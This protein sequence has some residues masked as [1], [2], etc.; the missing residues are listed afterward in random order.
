MHDTR[1][2]LTIQEQVPLSAWTSLR[3]GGPARYFVT[4]RSADVVPNAFE[5]AR[6]QSLPTLVLGGGSNVLVS[7]DGF[8]GTVIHVATEGYTVKTEGETAVLVRVAAGESWDDFVADAVRNG[9]W[10]IENL[11]LI[12]GKV[13]AV[14]IQNV[15]AYGQEVSDTI[16]SVEAWDTQREEWCTL[17]PTQ[18]AFGYRQSLFN[19][20]EADRYVIT[21][22]T[23]RLH[24]HGTPNLTH[25]AVAGALPESGHEASLDAMRRC[26][27][28]LR[29][30]GRL[31]DV[32]ETGNVGSF[33]KHVL[34]SEVELQ[35]MRDRMAETL[36]PT[37]AGRLFDLGQRFRVGERYKLPAGALIRA[38]GVADWQEGGAAQFAGNPLVLINRD[39]AAKAQDVRLLAHRI[40]DCVF[41]NS[42]IELTVEPR[43]IGFSD[44]EHDCR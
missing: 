34:L 8:S 38:C 37:I 43:C 27:I 3:M 23:F 12:P 7:D 2:E 5:F 14:P 4:L 24:L 30:D 36:D 21:Q 20:S 25:A 17:T 35:A 19:T 32:R 28:A 40:R 13:G 11:S 39:G 10:G 42:G 26:I 22:V 33:F 16:I 9:W 44:N 29:T 6:Q 1:H 31:P 41:E 18:C 15:G